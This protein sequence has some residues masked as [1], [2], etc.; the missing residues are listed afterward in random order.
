MG[1]KT[2][3]GMIDPPRT[4]CLHSSSFTL[5][6]KVAIWLLRFLASGLSITKQAG[7]LKALHL[8]AI[9]AQL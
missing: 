4:M 8:M 7:N 9:S 6:S 5:D 3:G 1:I 2:G